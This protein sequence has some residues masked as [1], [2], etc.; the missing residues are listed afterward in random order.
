MRFHKLVV[1]RRAENDRYS[2]A[3]WICHCDCG[4]EKTVTSGNLR[5]RR[6]PTKSCGCHNRAV[7]GARS[8][9]HGEGSIPR[10]ISREYA[11]W[12]RMKNRCFNP[13]DKRWERYGGRGLRVCVGWRDDYPRFLADMGRRPRGLTIDRINN[14]GHY[15]CGKCAECV[16][17]G[18]PANCRWASASQQIRNS[19]KARPIAAFG[20]TLILDDWSKVT[21]LKRTT[22]SERINRGWSV[23]EALS[24]PLGKAGCR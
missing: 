17:N 20:K 19:T 9:T 22:I 16:A 11:T 2:D 4:N 10:G 5:S 1:L 6:S 7:T 8:R 14:D 15:S 23:E 12:Q 13:H 18:W 21:G 24:L 3:D